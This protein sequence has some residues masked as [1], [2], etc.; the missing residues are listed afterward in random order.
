MSEGGGKSEGKK[1]RTVRKRN[2]E[3]CSLSQKGNPDDV[4]SGSDSECEQDMEEVPCQ[5]CNCKTTPIFQCG[6]CK[7]WFCMSCEKM[8][9]G[10]YN[11]LEKYPRFR[12]DCTS[13]EDSPTPTTVPAAGMTAKVEEIIEKTVANTLS[14]VVQTQMEKIGETLRRET[15]MKIAQIL[16]PK[17]INDDMN[18]EAE[19]TAAESWATVA[20]R[21]FQHT[22]KII[23]S[24]VTEVRKDETAEQER[25]RSIVIHRMPEDQE[26][27]GDRTGHDKAQVL[28]LT[29]NGLGLEIGIAKLIRLG[30]REEG[31]TRPLLVQLESDWDK[32]RLMSSLPKL[33][34][35]SEAH[36][37]LGI[38]HDLTKDQREKRRNLISEARQKKEAEGNTRFFRIRGT[39]DKL[40]VEWKDA[41]NPNPNE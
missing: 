14:S 15:D 37:G 18:E 9:K 28:D 5:K 29:K 1:R 24:A 25:Q 30:K 26:V 23:K 21:H 10:M 20:R 27:N 22:K 32:R 4:K 17:D 31:K 13:C 39:P 7:M 40:W 35:A 3:G 12:V 41:T 36:K 16:A 33:K 6:T 34:N 38:A 8:P 19:P 11:A 2:G